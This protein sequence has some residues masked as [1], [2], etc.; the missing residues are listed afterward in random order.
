M[1]DH[2]S[3][4]STLNL[5]AMN[6]DWSFGPGR[7]EDDPTHEFEIGQQFKNKK[8]VVI[9]VKMYSIRRAVEYKIS[10]CQDHGRLDSKAVAKHIFTMVK[11][12]PTISIRVL[13]RAIEN[14]FGYKASYRK[15][16]LAKQRVIAKIYR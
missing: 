4:C 13:Q 12:D 2:P 1:Y 8:E 11:A 9:A 5:D 10:D 7:F 15:V 16:W 3:H 6:V 14:H